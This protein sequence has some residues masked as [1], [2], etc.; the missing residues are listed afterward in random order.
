MTPLWLT[1]FLDLAADDH[2]AGTALW[3]RLTGYGVSSPRGEQGEFTTLPP[4]AGDDFLR[5]QR[6]DSGA[7]RVHVD[8]HVADV[9]E[10]VADAVALGAAVIDRRGYAVLSSPG[11]LPFCLASSRPRTRPAPTVWPGGHTSLLDQVCLDIPASS[12]AAEC[13]FWAGLTGWELRG[14]STHDEF[15]HLV[16]PPEQPLRLL[17]QR[18]DESS[19]PVRAHLDV[20]VN[21]REAETR[22]HLAAGSELVRHQEWWTVL[23][24]PRGTT[25]CLTDRDPKTGAVR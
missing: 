18:L 16:R 2:D 20:A 25:Y 19:G 9:D 23:R 17:L 4:L 3:S 1:A 14:S 5:V 8:I 15:Q 7:S 21:D 13:D 12:Y 11:G 24:G 22:R 10:A 6:L